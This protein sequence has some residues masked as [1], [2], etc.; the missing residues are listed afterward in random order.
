MTYDPGRM[1]AS[2]EKVK[3]DAPEDRGII[4]KWGDTI[5]RINF[6]VLAPK[7]SGKFNFSIAAK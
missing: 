3:L 1:Q 2:V 5:Y 4:T 7:P 6:K